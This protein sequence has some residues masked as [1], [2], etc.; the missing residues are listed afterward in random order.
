[1]H[2]DINLPENVMKRNAWVYTLAIAT[3]LCWSAGC[4]KKESENSGKSGDGGA[5]KLSKPAKELLV[6]TWEAKIELDDAKIDEMMT[7][8]KV[9]DAQKE[10]TKKMLSS[11]FG[12]MK[13]EVELKADG[14]LVRKTEGGGPQPKTDNGTWKVTSED[15]MVVKLESKEDGKDKADKITLTF[16]G[17]DEYTFDIDDPEFKEAP[18][19]T[20]ITFT[21]KK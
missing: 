5:K 4:G 2:E 16:S 10:D 7:K 17:D 14:T 11:M 1:M 13:M 20:P 9:P 12:K 18:F 19:K 6:G 8:K 21:R 3:L 15:G